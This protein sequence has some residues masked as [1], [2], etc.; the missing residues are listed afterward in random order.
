MEGHEA[1]NYDGEI[2]SAECIMHGMGGVKTVVINCS[3]HYA[4]F[5]QV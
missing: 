5:P 3:S 4:D 1:T 2:S